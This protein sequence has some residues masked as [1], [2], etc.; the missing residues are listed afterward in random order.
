[1]FKTFPEICLDNFAEIRLEIFAEINLENCV[2]R[3]QSVHGACTERAW[4]V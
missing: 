3:A 2:E 1:M 4:S